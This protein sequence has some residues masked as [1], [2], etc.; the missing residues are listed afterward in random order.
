VLGGCRVGAEVVLVGVP[1][2][3]RV[4]VLAGGRRAELQVFHCNFSF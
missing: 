2:G 1:A 3:G 4:V